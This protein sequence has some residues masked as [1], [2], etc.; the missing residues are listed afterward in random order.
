MN[1]KDIVEPKFN[2]ILL[3]IRLEKIEESCNEWFKFRNFIGN[4]SDN[5]TLNICENLIHNL[6]VKIQT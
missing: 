6:E 2:K 1:I 3:M 4:N 5:L